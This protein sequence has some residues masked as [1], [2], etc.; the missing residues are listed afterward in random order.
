MTDVAET[1]C[2]SGDVD[3]V[4]IKCTNESYSPTRYV[5]GWGFFLESSAYVALPVGATTY[6]RGITSSI[7]MGTI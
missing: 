6:S 3:A 7:K 5:P 2:Y 1:P 4:F